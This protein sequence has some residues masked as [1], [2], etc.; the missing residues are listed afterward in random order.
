MRMHSE[1][2]NQFIFVSYAYVPRQGKAVTGECNARMRI[3]LSE[4]ERL[5]DLTL[6]FV[7]RLR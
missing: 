6:E 7:G 4:D 5:R 3:D 1:E 2:A